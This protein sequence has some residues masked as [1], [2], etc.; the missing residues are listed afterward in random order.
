MLRASFSILCCCAAGTPERL[1]AICPDEL[2]LVLSHFTGLLHDIKAVDLGQ[3]HHRE[4]L[5]VR[6]SCC[7]AQTP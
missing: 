5:Q 6:G 7:L 1:A 3:L 2:P 4:V